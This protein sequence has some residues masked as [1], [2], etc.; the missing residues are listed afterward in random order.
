MSSGAK[1]DVHH[2]H[3]NAICFL[4]IVNTAQK[5]QGSTT[6]TS[7]HSTMANIKQIVPPHMRIHNLSSPSRKC[8]NLIYTLIPPGYTHGPSSPPGY[9]HDPSPPLGILM[10]RNHPLGITISC[11]RPM[12][13][14]HLHFRH[15]RPPQ[16]GHDQPRQHHVDHTRCHQPF[17]GRLLRLHGEFS[18]ACHQW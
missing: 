11:H 1:T 15:H 3:T 4:Q 13:E 6:T 9:P 14:P 10:A 5:I 2:T 8:T 16:S 17:L 18:R 7:H 12:R